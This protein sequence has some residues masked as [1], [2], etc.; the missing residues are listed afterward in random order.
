LQSR[1]MLD[2]MTA[3]PGAGAAGTIRLIGGATRNRLFL[4]I[5]ASVLARPIRVVE[6]PEATALGAALCAAVAAG[7]H[8]SFDAA[9]EALERREQVIEPDPAAVE[10]YERLLAVFA[11]LP[12]QLRP[13][14]WG[15]HAFTERT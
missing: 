8:P 12:G 13:V 3:L 15:L 1:L 5:K 4:A 9:L 10:R 14:S 7:V 2:G 6:E 11:R